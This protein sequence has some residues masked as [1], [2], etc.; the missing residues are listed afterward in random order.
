MPAGPETWL[1]PTQQ[2]TWLLFLRAS[3]HLMAELDRQ[4]QHDAG[5]PHSWYA[6][7]AVLSNQDDHSIRQKDLAAI[8]DFSFSRLSHAVSRLAARGW[9]ERRPHPTDG[10]AGLVVL[11][12]L[13]AE[14]LAEFKPGHVAAVRRHFVDPLTPRQLDEFGRSLA[15]ILASLPADPLDLA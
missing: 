14:I 11:T 7:M 10:R 4:L 2:R 5:I 12:D 15:K 3:G 9:V 8:I 1:T 6:V 13:G